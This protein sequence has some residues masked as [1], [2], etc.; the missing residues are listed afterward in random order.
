MRNPTQI[1]VTLGGL[2]LAVVVTSGL[3]AVLPFRQQGATHGWRLALS[4]AAFALAAGWVI[5]S[6]LAIPRAVTAIARRQQTGLAVTLLVAACVPVL[7]A[8]G[9]VVSSTFW[10]VGRG[11]G[12]R[13]SAF[14]HSLTPAQAALREELRRDVVVLGGEIGPRNAV[15]EYT[16][17]CRAADFIE[18]SFREMGYEVRRQD[19][20]PDH[21]AMRGKP[22]RNLEVEIRGTA[23]PDEIVVIGAHYDT[24]MSCPGANDNGSG[25]AALLA[26]ARRFQGQACGRTVRFVAFANEEPPFFWTSRMGSMVYAAACRA[27]RENIVAMMSLETL[28]YYSD[29]PG[30][31]HYPSRMF[32]WLYPTTGNFIS[33]IGNV[34]S[35]GLVERV[36]LSFRRHARFPSEGAAL[37]GLISGVG[38]SDHWSFWMH[39]YSGVMVT[40][41]A[42]FRY[43]HYH[44][45]EDTPDKLDYDRFAVV[46]EGLRGVVGDCAGM[47]RSVP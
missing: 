21:W 28:G 22:C 30:S 35:R 20:E 23:K 29:A 25:V 40:D 4:V 46:V 15:T 5:L 7:L 45:A 11:D 13:R 32:G 24:E 44:T 17:L 19:Y 16:N 27:R 38:W 14:R 26:L 10:T 39:G 8:T 42:P 18:T 12:R 31:Q 41:T 37:P 3:V 34:R 47:P 6:L 36:L 43:A 2:F 33:F 1:L 9:L